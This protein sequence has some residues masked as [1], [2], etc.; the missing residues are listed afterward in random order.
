[1]SFATCD[2]CDANEGKL[3][4][5]ALSVLPPIFHA[6]GAVSHFSGP[7][8]TLKLFEDNGMVRTVLETPGQGRVL[9]VDGGGSLRC[10]LLGGN[11]GV[12]AQNNG[13]AGVIV[14]GC[15]RDVAEINACQIGVRALGVMPVRSVKRGGG[16]HDVRVSIA[17]VAI[18]PGDWIYADQ[19]GILISQQALQ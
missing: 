11:L 15:I 14:H 8:S 13:W 16:E 2:L 9:V 18:H 3:A 17:G 19:D 12:L 6:Y 5:G 4:I 10:A 1:M 7:A